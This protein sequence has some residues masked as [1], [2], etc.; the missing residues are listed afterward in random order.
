ME[1]RDNKMGTMPI[2]QLLISMALPIIIS[3]LV[4]ALYNIVDS[5]F[6]SQI[7]ENALTAVSLA[8]PAQNLLIAFAGGTAVGINSLLSRSLG[9]KNQEHAN[10]TAN[11]AI[12]IWLVM[13]ILFMIIGVTCGKV[14]FAS[15][16]D[17]QEII[18][19]GTQYF[20]I[21]VGASF[22]LFGQFT[23]ERL[24]Q[25]TGRT[26]QTMITQ[27]LG[28]IIN[29]ILDPIF[30]FGM[31]GLPRMGVAGAALATVVGQ[32]IACFLGLYINQRYNHDI[33]IHIKHFKPNWLVIKQIYIVAIPSIIMQSIGSVMTYGLN[34]ILIGFSSTATAVFGVYFKLQSFFFMPIFGLNN[35]LIPIVAYNLG[36]RSKERMVEAMKRAM[37][38]A[39]GLMVLGFVVFEC[40]PAVLLGLFNASEHMLAIG[41]P[42]L[43]IIALHFIFAGVAIVCSAV[44]QACGKGMNSLIVS[45]VRQLIVL[46]PIAYLL[47]LFGNLNLVWLCF[48]ISEIVSVTISVL[49]IKRTFKQLSF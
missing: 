48:P 41:V 43:R 19:L 20:T 27:G 47:S 23:F 40:I 16:T 29:I 45:L 49:L 28:A 10:N 18:Q 15:Q 46:L 44:F 21:V 42:A 32:I 2:N 33:E 25:A 3:M 5:I 6:V 38:Y 7:S 35:A 9:E 12:M 8:F 14:F 11:H 24:L 1:A 36:A 37:I 39:T 17:D 4:Q 22:G 26:F 13:S 30:I 34:L 31:F